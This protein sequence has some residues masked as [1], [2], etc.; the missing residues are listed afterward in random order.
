MQYQIILLPQDGYWNW[1]RACKDYV[2]TYGVQLTP[3]PAS[4]AAFRAPRQVVTFPL[5]SGGVLDRE[6]IQAWVRGNH[7]GGRLDPIEASTPE[8]LE[9]ALA[10][11]HAGVI[12]PTT[13]GV[14]RVVQSSPPGST[15]TQKFGA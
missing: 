9:L 4:A 11:V 6:G 14:L 10:S 12:P 13:L 2:L 3:D 5:A 8:Q 7:P 1:V 15:I